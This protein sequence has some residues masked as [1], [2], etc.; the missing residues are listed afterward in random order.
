MEAISDNA[1]AEPHLPP[2][3]PQLLMPKKRQ[4]FHIKPASPAHH[5]LASGSHRDGGAGVS[6][7][8]SSS[9][10]DLISHLRRTQIP[11]AS[12][13]APTPRR[14]HF[15]PHSVPPSL[16]NIL[17]LPQIQPPRPRPGAP[18]TPIGSRPLRQ[19]AGPPPPHSWL[20]ESTT[21]EAKPEEYLGELTE[22][23]ETI[24]Y[25]LKR[26][27][28]GMFP[29]TA[30]LTHQVL[31][32]M[33]L[34]WPWHVEYDGTFLAQLPTHLKEL[35]LSYIGVFAKG[36][37]LNGSMKGLKPLFLTEQDQ[38]HDHIDDNEAESNEAGG[39][40]RNAGITRLDL[41]GAI[42]IW[43]SF[44]Q[45]TNEL[46]ISNASAVGASGSE[47]E[48][49]VPTSWDEEVHHSHERAESASVPAS[50][51]PSIPQEMT[52]KLRFENLRLLSLAHPNPSAANWISLLN[53]VSHLARITH[54][55]L[56]HWPIPTRTTAATNARNRY[57]AHH[58][59]TFGYSGADNHIEP[60]DNWAEAASILRQLSRA[61]YCLKWLDLEG[62]TAW[63]P[64][65]S[66]VGEDPDGVP[67]PLGAAGPDWNGAWRD[68]D[69]I[70]LGPGWVPN[71][72]DDDG[73]IS[74]DPSPA[75][76]NPDHA[77]PSQRE[78]EIRSARRL[79]TLQ[80]YREQFQIAL[81]VRKTLR[82]IRKE[83][84]GKWIEVSL[85]LDGFDP[86]IVRRLTGE[87]YEHFA[88]HQ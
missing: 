21:Q 6:G 3:T 43:M 16:R 5:S 63:L 13:D 70:R 33:A 38:H 82:V 7:R 55:S 87:K 22:D 12:E 26:L 11:S 57:P 34:N 76:E 81:D 74:H 40:D 61:T 56:A 51:A 31:K 83:C 52:H 73:D 41:G 2:S 64:A 69:W 18:H 46:I 37:L 32:T 49:D 85:G 23:M 1:R 79:K 30:D 72:T 44:K 35:L 71:M 8:S 36:H 42:G 60:A 77:A 17:E 25:R 28:S 45:L 47:R 48:E 58:S 66:W 4:R 10:N 50:Q 15:I 78:E 75:S 88:L 14:F 9:V 54:L 80:T 29:K 27:P 84:H 65:L 53:L 19:T 62:C 68:V 24:I 39:R 67:Y 86:Q 59:L 20:T